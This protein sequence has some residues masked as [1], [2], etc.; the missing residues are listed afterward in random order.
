[1]IRAAEASGLVAHSLAVL[2]AGNQEHCWED[3]TVP[4]FAAE[5]NHRLTADAK[6]PATEAAWTAESSTGDTSKAV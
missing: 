2:F 3:S 5:P 1:M 6:E 4:G